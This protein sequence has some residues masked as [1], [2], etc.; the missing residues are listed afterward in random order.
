MRLC[1]QDEYKFDKNPFAMDD[2]FF[3][4]FHMDF[5]NSVI[6]SKKTPV[7]N[8]KWINWKKMSGYG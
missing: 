1:A 7:L 8:Q 2:R 3:S 5:Y 6:L 4:T